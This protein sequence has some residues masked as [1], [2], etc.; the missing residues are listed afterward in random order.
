MEQELIKLKILLPT[1]L[2]LEANDVSSLVVETSKGSMGI[3]PH[4]LDCVAIIT[5]GI[6]A[7]K[8]SSGEETF[9]AIDDG[10]LTK[11][12]LDV[13]ILVHNAISGKDLS[14]LKDEVESRFMQQDEEETDL[15]QLMGKIENSLLSHLHRIKG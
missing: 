11:T 6:L 8:S 9:V 7:L 10:V 12:G 3:L 14:T 13:T 1:E 15:N 4:R 2:S 5:P